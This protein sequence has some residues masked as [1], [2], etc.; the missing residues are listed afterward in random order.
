MNEFIRFEDIG[1]NY[2]LL[3]ILTLNGIKNYL[4]HNGEC[5]S[6]YYIGLADPRAENEVL[7]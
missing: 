3:Q 5:V 6:V 4:Y 1:D 7:N 2:I